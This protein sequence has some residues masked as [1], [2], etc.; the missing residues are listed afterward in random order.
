MKKIIILLGIAASLSA[1]NQAKDDGGEG[2]RLKAL[3]EFKGAWV[4]SG[5]E[6][7]GGE[8]CGFAFVSS[9]TDKSFTL[10][11]LVA[12]CRKTGTLGLYAPMNFKLTEKSK[13]RVDSISN[14]APDSAM[15]ASRDGAYT[16]SGWIDVKTSTVYF[17]L[18]TDEAP[19]ANKISFKGK[20][21]NGELELQEL[22]IANKIS[23]DRVTLSS[24]LT[25]AG[26]KLA[27]FDFFSNIEVPAAAIVSTA[28]ANQNYL[29]CSEQS[30]TPT[31]GLIHM[32]GK[33]YAISGGKTIG[34]MGFLGYGSSTVNS[35]GTT[36]GSYRIVDEWP[37]YNLSLLMS[38]G[39]TTYGR[40]QV[41][42]NSSLL[43]TGS[44][45][46]ICKFIQNDVF[47]GYSGWNP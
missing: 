24:E 8:R 27:Q 31:R 44:T 34:E 15:I 35:V 38:G 18:S 2:A 11:S 23:F 37:M 39:R 13:A 25:E 21:L 33:R 46:M 19:S 36:N 22:R 20:V 42:G 45:I 26:V 9:S 17:D 14:S 16:N 43:L 12:D 10:S 32:A 6:F 5:L 40:I 28:E 4:A 7:S 3:G 30:S 29:Y 41:V 1:C 47:K